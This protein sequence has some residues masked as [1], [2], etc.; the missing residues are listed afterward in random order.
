VPLAPA[1]NALIR[2][3]RFKELH[4]EI[5][6]CQQLS[7]LAG[8]PHC[9]ALE[10]VTGA[11]K[12]TLVKSYA[13]SF[14]RSETADG[15][16]LPVLYLEVPSPATVK[17][18]AAAMLMQLGD[19]GATKGTLWSMN[20]RVILFIKCRRTIKFPPPARSNKDRLLVDSDKK[21]SSYGHS[22]L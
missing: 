17:G 15:A 6:R 11:G 19:P 1:H 18:V 14:Q 16:R 4:E 13:Q 20:E 8:E 5:E 22:R 9:I 10:G 12:S 3:P 2:Y 7:R 21:V